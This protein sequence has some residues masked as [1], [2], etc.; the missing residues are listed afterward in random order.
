MKKYKN[1]STLLINDQPAINKVFFLDRTINLRKVFLYRHGKR[2]YAK[3]HVL[4]PFVKVY[5]KI[6]NNN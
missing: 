3:D 4:L 5:E 6:Q 2:M 1:Y